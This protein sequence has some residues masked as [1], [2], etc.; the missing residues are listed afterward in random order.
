ME[1]DCN[2]IEVVGEHSNTGG[3]GWL[4][5]GAD[6]GWICPKCGRVYSPSTSECWQCN[7]G[8]SSSQITWTTYTGTGE[9]ITMSSGD[10]NEEEREAENLA[11]N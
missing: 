1:T 8:W 11:D 10:Y 6:R 4:Y 5:Y 7:N 3:S 9:T 2:Y